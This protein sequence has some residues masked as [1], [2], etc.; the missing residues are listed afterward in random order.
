M[1][2]DIFPIAADQ[3]DSKEDDIA[4]H[5]VGED[6]AVIEEDEGVEQASGGGEEQSVGERVGFDGDAGGKH[7]LSVVLRVD[8]KGE[9]LCRG[10]FCELN[11]SVL[12]VA[13]R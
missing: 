4:S 12:R 7:G 10:W 9:V 13:I 8:G 2:N 3:G 1:G 5:G 11:E 6:M